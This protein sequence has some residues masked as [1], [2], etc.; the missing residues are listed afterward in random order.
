MSSM[1]NRVLPQEIIL[2]NRKHQI[3]EICLFCGS[4]FFI[5][6]PSVLPGNGGS[7]VEMAALQPPL[8]RE[9]G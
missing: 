6:L 8:E 2:E 4:S 1:F 7:Q 9:A 5:L 3:F